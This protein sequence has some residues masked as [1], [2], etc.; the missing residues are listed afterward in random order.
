MQLLLSQHGWL[1]P[2]QAAHVPLKHTVPAAEQMPAQQAWPMPPQPWQ[3]PSLHTRLLPQLVP[4]ATHVVPPLPVQQPPALH[5]PPAPPQHGC[6]GPPH[7]G[8]LQIPPWQ[9]SD[10]EL[11]TP[12]EQQIWL[13]PPHSWQY[14]ID[15]DV[16]QA[17]PGAVQVP[18]IPPQQS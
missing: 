13:V 7:M 6:P 14:A 17:V 4:G 1:G 2:P 8:T 15:P 12:P 18:P 16:W 9:V 3:L 11:Q 5:I 10:D